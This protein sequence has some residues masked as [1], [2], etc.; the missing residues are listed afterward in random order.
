MGLNESYRCYSRANPP[1]ESSPSRPP[2]ILLCLKK[3]SNASLDEHN[4]SAAVLWRAWQRQSIEHGRM[5]P[6]NRPS[7]SQN[8]RSAHGFVEDAPVLVLWRYGSLGPKVFSTTWIPTDHPKARMNL[9]SN[10]NRNKSFSAN[11]VSRRMKRNCS[12]IVEAQLK[13]LLSLLNNQ[14]ENSSSKVNAVTKPCLSKV[15]SNWIID[16]GATDHITSS[17]KL[18]HKDKI[19]RYTVLLPSGEKANIV[20]KGLCLN[21][22]IIRMMSYLCLHSKHFPLLVYFV[23]SATRRTIGL[24]KQRDGLYYLVALA[25]EKSL[26]NHSSSTNQPAAIS[27]SLPSIYALSLPR[28]FEFFCSSNNACPICPLAKQSRLPFDNGVIFQHSC[29]YTPQQNGV[30]E[31]KH[32]H[33]LQVA[34]ALKFHAQVPTQFWGECALTAVHIINRLPSPVLSFKTPFELLYSKP[35]SYSHL[36]VFGCLAYAT[37]VHTSHKFDYRAMPS[38]FIGYPAGQKAYKLFDLSTKKVFTSRDVK[39]HEDIFPYVSLKPNSTLPSLTHNSGPIPLV[40]HDISSSLDS[41]SHI[42]P[43]LSPS[44]STTL[45][46]PSPGPPFASIPSVPPDE[47]P[48]L[49]PKHNHPNQPLRS[50]HDIHRQL[51]FLSRYKPAYRSFVLFGSAAHPEWRKAML[52]CKLSKLMALGFSLH[53]RPRRHRLVDGSLQSTIGSERFYSIRRC[54]LSGYIFPTAKIISSSCLHWRT[55]AGHFI[56]WMLTT[57]FFMA[58]YMRKYICLH[59]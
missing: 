15:A 29:V 4:E 46:S 2:S 1:D 47:T 34:R 49:S 17:S 59:R 37:N 18:L 5:E 48:I 16:S 12:C 35:P 24:G 52:N 22:S 44:P 7:G 39:F 28:I 40:A 58:T 31:R 43:N 57:L 33:I 50:V 45:V 51:C 36:R 11:Q 54:R 10:S 8:F 20:T 30:V 9:G 19:A 55:V 6:T 3:K 13:Q 38:I 53:F 23:G 56:K 32:R 41:T 26:T 27:P 42:D 21:S 14:D 25:T